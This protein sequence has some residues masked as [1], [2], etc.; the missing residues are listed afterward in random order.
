MI[1]KKGSV[2]DC[3]NY[4]PIGLLNH[5]YKILSVCILT[6]RLMK[7]TKWFLSDWQSGFRQ[8]R[9]CRDNILLLRVIY[10]NIIKGD[11]KCV[12]TFIDY[13]GAFDSISHKYLDAALKNAG[14][15]RKTRAL[16]RKIYAAAAG[17]ARIQGLD[18]KTLLS[19]AFEI[20]RGVIQGDIISP[21]FF[22]LALDQ[23]MQAYDTKGTGIKVGTIR[24]MRV[25]GYADDCTMLTTNTDIMTAR[26]TTF[27]DASLHEADMKVKPS[28]TFSQHVCKQDPVEKPTDAEIAAKEST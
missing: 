21:I 12:V 9:G 3:A 7:E 23:L 20:C 25:L 2:N 5:S 24:K 15:S 13:A 27:A 1:Y 6:S 16:F 8:L 19:K 14:A 28:K 10:D 18:G 17:A 22:I 26:L 11:T 4:R